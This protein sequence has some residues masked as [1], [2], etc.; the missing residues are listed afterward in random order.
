MIEKLEMLRK[1][2]ESPATIM[3]GLMIV[4]ML[5]GFMVGSGYG[6]GYRLVQV[7]RLQDKNRKLLNFVNTT[8]DNIIK[9][10]FKKPL[11]DY[12]NKIKVDGYSWKLPTPK[13]LPTNGSKD[14]TV[15]Q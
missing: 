12:F 13:P 2:K 6:S 15:V 14:T 1:L 4:C 3:V 7:V 8:R 11:T 5:M 9:T 10:G